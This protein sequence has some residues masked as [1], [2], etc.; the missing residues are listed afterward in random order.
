MDG[1]LEADGTAIGV[2]ADSLE[3]TVRK[4][5]VRQLLLEGRLLLL[6]PHSPTAGF[7]IGGALG[8]NKMIYGLANYAVIVNSDY[9]TGG[10]WAGA[11]EALKHNWCPTFVRDAEDV[12]KGNRELIKLGA[13]PLADSQLATVENIGEWMRQHARRQPEEPELFNL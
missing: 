1:A 6:T 8:R 4:S 3:S 11:V 7:T 5:D 9:Q 13:A 10:T 2:L 12:G